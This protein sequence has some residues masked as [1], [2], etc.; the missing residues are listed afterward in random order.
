MKRAL[1]ATTKVPI[2]YLESGEEY[3]AQNVPAQQAVKSEAVGILETV[4]LEKKRG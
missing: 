3:V 2:K 1:P 4:P